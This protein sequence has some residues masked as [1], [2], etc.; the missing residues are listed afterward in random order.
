MLMDVKC[1]AVTSIAVHLTFDDGTTKNSVLGVGDLVSVEYNNN[2][3][4]KQV[5]GK[6]LKISAIGADPK[7]WYIIVDGSDEFECNKARFSPMSILD[8]EILRKA[9]NSNTIQTPVGCH[10]VSFLREV[11]GRLQWSRDGIT[12][13][14]INIDKCD[15]IEDKSVLEDRNSGCDCGSGKDDDSSDKIKDANY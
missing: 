14:S 12:W 2:G 13:H 5:D 9:D 15:I 4:R 3:L 6:V 7:A 11:K 8:L 1:S 10:A